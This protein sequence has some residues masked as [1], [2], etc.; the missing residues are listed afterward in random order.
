MAFIIVFVGGFN[1]ALPDYSWGRPV[2]LVHGIFVDNAVLLLYVFLMV[3]AGTARN[4]LRNTE[5]VPFAALVALLA[6]LGIVSAGVNG[7]SLLDIGKCCRL[8]LFAIYVLLLVHWTRARGDNFVLRTLLIGIAL[9]GLVNFYFSFTEPEL[10]I[11]LLPVLRSQNGAGGLLGIAVSLSAWL[12][13]IGQS[14]IDRVVAIIS[15]LVGLSAAAISF[16]KTSMTIAA[17]GLMAW[18]WVLVHFGISR[19]YRLVATIAAVLLF[20]GAVTAAQDEQI[21]DYIS[22]I[23]KAVTMKFTNVSLNDKY[24]VGSRYMYFWGVLDVVAEH[25]FLGVSYSGFYDAIT[26]TPTYQTGQ[27]ADEDPEGGKTGQANPHNS[28]LNYAAANGVPGFLIAIALYFSFLGFLWSALDRAG[29]AGRG[30]WAAMALA[31]FIYAM[32]LPTLYDTPTLFVPAAMAIAITMQRRAARYGR[33]ELP[34]TASAP[35]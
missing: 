34:A 22:S 14:R 1:M 8:L 21:S 4:L 12:M 23:S 18:F 13:F 24:S 26:H 3:L 5:A 25:P 15:G 30:I 33:Y 19:R 9:G 28:F 6:C 20:G 17:C 2:Q 29:L 27:M 32:T 31:Y 10:S 11:G 35:S 16:S 7:T